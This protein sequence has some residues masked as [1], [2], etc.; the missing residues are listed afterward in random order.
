MMRFAKLPASND[1]NPHDT[2]DFNKRSPHAV[3]HVRGA[4]D[5][6]QWTIDGTRI[7]SQF[8]AAALNF[9]G[10]HIHAY[11]GACLILGVVAPVRPEKYMVIAESDDDRVAFHINVV[12]PC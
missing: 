1:I 4:A 5:S 3:L 7:P 9:N 6:V 2:V 12:P 11:Q 10:L 8:Q